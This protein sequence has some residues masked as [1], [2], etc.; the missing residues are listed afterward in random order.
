MVG[1][2]AKLQLGPTA[3]A[4]IAKRGRRS[5]G[6]LSAEKAVATLQNGGNGAAALRDS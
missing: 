1:R 6:A 2:P 4:G 3:A 5:S